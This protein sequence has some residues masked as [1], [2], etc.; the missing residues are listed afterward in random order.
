MAIDWGS[1]FGGGAKPSAP[2][3]GGIDWGNV[4]SKSKEPEYWSKARANNLDF[5]KIDREK[6]KTLENVLMGV[7]GNSTP[8]LNSGYK[9]GT[10]SA[11]YAD[12][13]VRN[14]NLASPVT[15][16]KE[17]ARG[18]KQTGE[19][20]MSVGTKLGY[21]MASIPE[22]AKITAASELSPWANKVGLGGLTDAQVKVSNEFLSQFGNKSYLPE[23]QRIG[24]KKN[25]SEATSEFGKLTLGEGLKGGIEIAPM[26]TGG[27][28]AGQ[29]LKQAGKQLGLTSVLS[30]AGNVAYNAPNYEGSMTDKLKQAGVDFTIG[31]G[32]ELAT[33]GG[34]RALKGFTNKG[35]E[36]FIENIV[37]QKSSKAIQKTLA[38]NGLA[39]LS[40]VA[41]QLAATRTK[42]EAKQVLFD[43]AKKAD[44]AIYQNA[45]L[46]N[47]S[48]GININN[49]GVVEAITQKEPKAIAEKLP[50]PLQKVV[51][52]V[53]AAK[54]KA[55]YHLVNNMQYI[56]KP[57]K[58]ATDSNTGRKVTEVIRELTGNVRQYAGLAQSRRE[59]NEAFQKL[60]EFAQGLGSG[61][62]GARNAFKEDIVP[63]LKEKQDA[64]NRQKLGEKVTIP[65]GTTEQEA[66]Y[67]LLNK[68][69]KN[70]VQYAFDNGLIDETK[71]RQWISDPDYTRVQR[72]IED[73]I[74]GGSGH[75]EASLASTVTSQK[76]K[77]SDKE[78]LD[79]IAAY[80]DW[81]NNITR[82]VEVNKLATY[83]S[84]Q[85]EN[86][87]EGKLTK[88]TNVGSKTLARFNNGMKELVETD[89][90][91]V[92]SIK[93]MDSVMFGALNKWVNFPS[94]LLKV[95]ATGL[96]VAF[97]V[98][99]FI[100]DQIES[101]IISKNVMAT[102]NPAV[103]WQGIK[104]STL[105]PVG[106]AVAGKVGA[107]EAFKPS[108]LFEEFMKRN[109]NMTTVDLARELKSA[110][111]QGY[112]ELGL[113]R[114]SALRTAEDIVSA[115][116]V[117]TRYQNFIGQYRK[118]L[119][120]N[121]DPQEAIRR[122]TQASRENSIDFSQRGELAGFMRIFNPYLPAATQGARNLSRAFKERPVATSLKVGATILAPVSA[123]TYWNLSDPERARMY[124]EIP[125]YER[126]TNLIMV[127]GGDRGFIKVPIPPGV[128][129]MA[130]PL[131]N[132]IESEYLGD[133]QGLLETAKNMF[134]DPFNP[135]GSS[136]NEVL[137]NFVPQGA[138][139]IVQLATNRDLYTGDEIV[140]SYLKD[141]KTPEKQ[142]FKNTSQ[143]YRDI[144]KILGVSPLQVKSFVKG[145]GAGGGEQILENTDIARKAAG[146]D[147]STGGRS[148][149]EQILGRF[150][151][152]EPTG[153]A[154]TTRFYDDLA[155][156][157]VGKQ[158][159]SD[160]VTEA[161]KNGDYGLAR[162][163]IGQ[164][165]GKID[166]MENTYKSTYGKYEDSE[167]S[168]KLF[169]N[170]KK[171]KLSDKTSSLNARK[172]KK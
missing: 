25:I 134:V 120:N 102:H 112:E 162:T 123:A 27:S 152:K 29:G 18:A 154:V 9:P 7:A 36:K 118:E 170:L 164:F 26:V 5:N 122:A 59:A 65:K 115:T 143:S 78:M 82:E 61:K 131:R 130:K 87:G 76:L 146:Q 135:L 153:N 96:N 17:I 158:D 70:E 128:S 52:A 136:K 74:S 171:L 24:K 95:G 37:E 140:P 42:A 148:T 49:P 94:R 53:G 55:I 71:Y 39:D 157:T 50:S 147:I 44:A 51:S 106:R 35:G 104:E 90:Q 107:K 20:L 119:K 85:L 28:L 64:L 149:L 129:H 133:R 166:N 113:K 168:S 92:K 172:K 156:V 77:G 151:K 56:E 21:T 68:A 14:A 40:S 126:E 69:T 8:Y 79:P 15:A 19:G 110:T 66:A 117:S 125:E 142:V 54:D 30:G 22:L 114:Q 3:G 163:L 32:T 150:Y 116:E 91:I 75:A 73:Q 145:Y 141:N 46:P 101:A 1:V 89:P 109:K 121:V 43:A 159:I 127:L 12:L 16:A 48:K 124:A 86:I 139:P 45:P 4:F 97:T 100:K 88:A 99:N 47:A 84:R 60:G 67:S 72:E 10:L 111:R 57:F 83:V 41:T 161:A 108:P 34:G 167:S 80:I 63:F 138:K 165:N 98:P 23:L 155:A 11:R 62:R 160:A 38:D 13:P 33:Y 169:E 132:L 144:G 6:Q 93:E 137:G 58:G 105:K 31:A 103:F 2:S 81:S